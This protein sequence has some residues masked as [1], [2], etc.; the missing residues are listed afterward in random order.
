MPSISGSS[1]YILSGAPLPDNYTE[2]CQS[3]GEFILKRL[4]ENG[5]SVVLVSRIYVDFFFHDDL[6][7]L[8]IYFHPFCSN[9]NENIRS[10]LQSYRCTTPKSLNFF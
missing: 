6:L 7:S 1:K 9:F 2:G 8:S 3:F 5:D 10:H 4:K